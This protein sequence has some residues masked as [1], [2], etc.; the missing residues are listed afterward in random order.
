MSSL[1]FYYK[2]TNCK[3]ANLHKILHNS[4]Q[5]SPKSLL[6]KLF[7]I[8]YTLYPVFVIRK[9]TYLRTCESFK[10]AKCMDL[11]IANSQITNPPITNKDWI[12]KCK[13]AKWL[14]SGRSAFLTNYLSPHVSGFA[15][16]GTYLRTGHL[17]LFKI[18][19][20]RKISIEITSKN[21]HFVYKPYTVSLLFCF[22]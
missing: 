11:Q 16:Y 22:Y 13:S 10:S 20:L 19:I 3:S 8:L 1:P 6:L 17:C 7:L 21:N 5:N 2:L 4:S 9:N 14:I 12:R 15:I 18:K